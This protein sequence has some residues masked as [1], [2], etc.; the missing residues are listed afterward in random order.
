MSP[1]RS[2]RARATD[3]PT[4]R[5]RVQPN[6][7]MTCYRTSCLCEHTC[8]PHPGQDTGTATASAR[9]SKPCPREQGDTV[10]IRHH[11]G[12]LLD[13]T[14]RSSSVAE[15]GSALACAARLLRVLFA[16]ATA[17]NARSSAACSLFPVPCPPPAVPAPNQPESQAPEIAC[18]VSPRSC[19]PFWLSIIR[20]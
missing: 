14:E 13:L 17:D 8:D 19:C 5:L 9:T 6:V 18:H 2:G 7:L 3:A 1:G 15:P 4:P 16:S 11:A 20:T 12:G 10:S